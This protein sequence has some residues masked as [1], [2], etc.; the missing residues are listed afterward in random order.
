MWA[1]LALAAA[2]QAVPAQP[3]AFALKNPRASHGILGQ[4][5]KDAKYLAGD[6]VVVNYELQ[7]LKVPEDN[8]V[9]YSLA[10]EVT[11]KAGKSVYKLEPQEFKAELT[12][13]GTSR[14][15]VSF[16]ELQ[17]DTLPGEYVFTVTGIDLL[18]KQTNKLEFPFE[19]LSPRLGFIQTGVHIPVN[20]NLMPSPAMIPV[21]QTVMVGA[22]VVGFELGPKTET[23]AKKKQPHIVM[24]TRIIDEATGKATLLKP[25]VGYVTTVNEEVFK[26]V[27]PFT[28]QLEL[29]R[30]GKYRI[31]MKVTDKHADKMAEMSLEV[32]VFEIK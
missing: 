7:N 6:F 24:E 26:K 8:I 29:N 18:G 4:T 15:A 9:Q 1:T 20:Q 30:P 14:P 5:R 32:T 31:E 16:Y 3:G 11:T 21:G 2:L 12:L 23:D 28:T 27:L 10:I 19:V 22:A 17:M 25:K 13:G